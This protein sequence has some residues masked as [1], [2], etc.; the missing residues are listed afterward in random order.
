MCREDKKWLEKMPQ[1]PKAAQKVQGAF[2]KGAAKGAAESVMFGDC[3][4]AGA[5]GGAVSSGGMAMA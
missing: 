4:I 1:G 5:A 2:V 3:G